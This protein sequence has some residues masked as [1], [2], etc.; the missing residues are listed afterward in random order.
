MFTAFHRRLLVALVS[1]LAFAAFP[2]SHLRTTVGHFHK[3]G[4][5]TRSP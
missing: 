2:T 4:R 1:F 5:S 3:R